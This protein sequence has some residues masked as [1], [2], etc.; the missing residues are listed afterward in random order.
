MTCP[1]TLS[2]SQ[3][4]DAPVDDWSAFPSHDSHPWT[5]VSFSEG[6][7]DQMVWLA[8]TEEHVIRGVKSA[9]WRFLPS[10]LGYWVA[11]NY[12]STSAYV[13]RK[14]PTEWTSCEVEFDPKFATAV[15]RKWRCVSPK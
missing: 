13:A 3:T 12:G 15:V 11:C 1:Q 10:A 5:G 6:S 9:T 2:V 8:P 4:I 7:P 14:L